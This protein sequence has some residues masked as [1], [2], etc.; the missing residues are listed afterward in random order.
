MI[1]V[2]QGSDDEDEN[3]AEEDDDE[4]GEVGSGGD[5]DEL[6][7]SGDSDEGKQKN[8]KGKN[9]VPD[10]P[11]ESESGREVAGEEDENSELVR[12]RKPRKFPRSKSQVTRHVSLFLR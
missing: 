9:N 1:D 2:F 4:D 12:V 8:K 10:K 7:D 11:S 3:D 5:D 6:E